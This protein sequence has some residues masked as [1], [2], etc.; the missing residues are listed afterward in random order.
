MTREPG[1][2]LILDLAGKRCVVVG[3]GEVAARKVRAL[4]VSGADVLVVAP[5]VAPE[6]AALAAQG[7]LRVE[8]RPFAASDLDGA[9]LA[10][11]ATDSR[12]VNEAVATG[13]RARSIF[14]N[15][16]DDPSACDFTV[17]ATVRRGEVT[18]SISTGGRSP[19]FARF[20]REQLEAWLT[21]ARTDLL[22]LAAELRRELLAGGA[23][24]VG[25]RWQAALADDAAMQSL[26]D[27]DR[28]AARRRLREILTAA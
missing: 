12:A 14:V 3:G 17:P 22:E 13:A 6:L 27:G 9:T 24:I 19:A 21:D 16:A 25:E 20:L 4:I 5:E 2:P 8:Q 10:F 18:L 23:R 28:D 11:A 1:Y 26:A 7:A 15:V